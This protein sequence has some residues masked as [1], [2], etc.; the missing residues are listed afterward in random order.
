[1]DICEDQQVEGSLT[2]IA[3]LVQDEHLCLKIIYILLLL[4]F[5]FLMADCSARSLCWDRV[6]P[7]E[8]ASK[9][10]FGPSTR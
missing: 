10:Q 6:V 2:C 5:L 3:A 7:Y 9:L 8:A 1:M 4:S